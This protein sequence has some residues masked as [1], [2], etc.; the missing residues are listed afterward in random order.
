MDNERW[1]R[2]SV[3]HNAWLEANA[4]A[5]QR[6]QDEL[7]VEQ[8]ELVEDVNALLAESTS[9]DGFLE[10]PALVSAAEELAALPPTL[11]PGTNVGPYRIVELLA[12]GGMGDVYRA[13]DVRLDRDVALKVLTHTAHFDPR[14]V[15]RFEQEARA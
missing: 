12:Q 4:A 11:R 15:N 14:S 6:M 2:L 10:T 1:N 7:A 13:L 5:R 3:W 9:L 8:P